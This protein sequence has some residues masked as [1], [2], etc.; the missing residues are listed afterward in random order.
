MILTPR[1]IV[2]SWQDGDRATFHAMS[3]DP[4][5]MQHLGPLQTRA[6][7]DAVIDRLMAIEEDRGHTFWAVERRDDGAFIGFCGL[8]IAPPGIAGLE[9]AIEIGW[10][11]RREAWGAGFARE[12]ATACLDWGWANLEDG[13]IVAIT[14][15]ANVRSW[16]LMERLGMTRR[17]D[18]DFAHPNVAPDN[19]LSAH[20]TYEALRI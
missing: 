6:E 13:R 8:K 2:R 4:Q 7:S 11:L 14:T 5:V 10:R 19:P 9:D 15:A 16:G 3:Q 18:L 12:A 17:N 1:L 20:I